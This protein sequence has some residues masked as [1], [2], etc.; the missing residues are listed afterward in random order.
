MK[1]RLR[2]VALDDRYT[3]QRGR[4]LLTGIQALTRLP[5]IQSARDRK[6]GLNTAGFISGY[7][8]S[9]L[10]GLDQQ[11]WQASPLLDGAGVRFQPGLNE[12]LAATA[13]SGSQH[14]GSFAGARHDGV[15]AMWYGKAPGVD[16]ASDAFRHGNAAGSSRRGG[17]LVVAGDDHAAK[18]SS[19]PSQ[20]EYAFMDLGIPVLN[21]AD[22]QDVLDFGLYGWALSRYSGCWVALIALADTMDSSATV[23][24]DIER[25]RIIIPDDFGLPAGGVNLRVGAGPLEQEEMLHRHRLYAALAFGRANRLDRTVIESPR[26]RFGI[27][28]T[29][30]AYLDVRQ[31]LD[32]LG[33]DDQ[34]AAEL[35]LRL[36]KV[37][38]SWP[39]ERTGMLEFADG[40]DEILVVE[41]KRGLIENQLKEQLYNMPASHRPRVVGKF[42]EHGRWLLPSM[43]DLSPGKIARVIA[44][45][46]PETS[47]DQQVRTRLRELRAGEAALAAADDVRTRQPFY[48]SGCPHNISTKLPDGSRALA[49]IGCHYM[50]R[51]MGFNSDTY[52]QMGGEGVQWIGQAPFTDEPHV[53]TNLGDGTYY[54]SGLL[55]VRAAVAAGVNITYKILFNDAVAMTGG[56]PV[57]GPLTIDTITQQIAAEGVRRMVVVSDEPEK[58][59]KQPRFVDH[60]TVHHRRELRSL[61]RELRETEGC[62]VIV[63]DQTCAAELRRRRKRGTA[64]DRPVRAFINADVCEGCGDCSEQSNCVSVEPLETEL[65][66]KRA[67]NQTSCNKDLAC[68]D[69]LC[70]AF[71]TVHGGNLRRSSVADASLADKLRALPAP[72]AAL[73]ERPWNI[74]ITGIGGTGIVTAGALLGMAAHLERRGCTTLDMTGL[75]QKNG[76]VISH[77]RIGRTQRDIHTPRVPAAEADVV[78]GCDPVVAA[79]RDCVVKMNRERTHAVLN[80]HVSPT[81]EFVLDNTTEYDGDEFVGLVQRLS[82]ATSTLDATRITGRLFG[83]AVTVNTFLLGYAFQAGLLPFGIEAMARAIELNGVAVEANKRAFDHGRLAAHDRAAIDAATRTEAERPNLPLPIDNLI[84][85]RMDE[86]EAYQDAALAGRYHAL[87]DETRA[88]ENHIA[89]GAQELTRAVAESFFKLLAYKDEYEV[90]RLYSEPEFRQQLE[91]QFEGDYRLQFHLAPAWLTKRDPVTGEPRKRELGPWML[92]VFG[93]L[94]KFRFLRGTPLDPFGYGHDRRVERQLISEYEK[95]VDELLVQLKPTNYR[96]A[97][98]IAALPEQIRG[99]GPVKERSI[100]KARQQEK[101]LREQLAK[102]DEVQSVR[103]FQPAA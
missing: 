28:T 76:A 23:D 88:A 48:C 6:A 72:T 60:A 102:G 44:G 42:D 49:G 59:G 20:S 9:P 94:A 53:F 8:G 18:S 56:Q 93:V 82:A 65:G 17:V 81:A 95:T 31:A 69:G 96:T 3:R 21:P 22:V 74:V 13:V 68:V 15:F 10:A 97:V 70:P 61:E 91:A 55:A 71:V 62:T 66:R 92:N 12:E 5:L 32:D 26:A 4:I 85:R 19:L 43:G 75:S 41:E 14:V 58:Y 47:R 16:R 38:M 86:L 50:V 103:L 64:P 67:I 77:V 2:D 25:A 89:P 80:T 46:L 33:L 45:R 90:A 63:Y 34:R 24:A 1:V 52:S 35:G 54:H 27:V 40:L 51:W 39:L 83:D 37:G 78:I 30:K 29:G 99:Y 57:D 87:V 84:E 7:R 98:A 79:S 36:Y 101:L 11:L 73:L 100:A